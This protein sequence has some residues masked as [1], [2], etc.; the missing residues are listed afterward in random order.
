MSGY[1][2]LMLLDAGSMS[3]EEIF[4]LGRTIKVSIY[5]SIALNLVVIVGSFA[6][7]MRRRCRL[8]Y[9]KKQNRLKFEDEK[10]LNH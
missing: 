4:S 7:Q 2:A 1:Y 9:L 10:K 5:T 3:R 8:N 6:I